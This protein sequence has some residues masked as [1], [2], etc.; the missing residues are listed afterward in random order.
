MELLHPANIYSEEVM[1]NRNR[2][3]KGETIGGRYL[4]Q[5]VLIGGMG[6]VYLCMDSLAGAPRA[7][8]TFQDQFLYDVDIRERFA[9]EALTWAKLGRHPNIVTVYEVEKI[10]GKP[11][12]IMEVVFGPEGYGSDLRSWLASGK[13]DFE[14]SMDFAVQFCQGMQFVQQ[15][16]PGLI[17]RDIKPENILINQNRILKISDFGLIKTWDDSHE[18]IQNT[19]FIDDRQTDQSSLVGTPGYMSPEQVSGKTLD[20]RSDIFSFGCVF[21]EMLTGKIPS[22]GSSLKQVDKLIEKIIT[23][24]LQVEPKER[25]DSFRG[26]E[27]AILQAYQELTGHS[28]TYRSEDTD[29][30]EIDLLNRAHSL[31]NLGYLDDALQE[32]DK[33]TKLYPQNAEGWSNKGAILAH[34]ER[35]EEALIAYDMAIKIDPRHY[36]A[37]LNKCGSL[38]KLNRASEAI[39]ILDFIL[40]FS[41]FPHRVW[42]NKGSAFEKLGKHDE[43]LDCYNRALQIDPLHTQSWNNKG[44]VEFSKYLHGKSPIDQ[45]NSL[46]NSIENFYKAFEIDPYYENA[47]NNLR[48]AINYALSDLP[49]SYLTEP[50]LWKAARSDDSSREEL[51]NKIFSVEGFE[52]HPRYVS[53]WSPQLSKLMRGEREALGVQVNLIC[54]TILQRGGSLVDWFQYSDEQSRLVLFMLNESLYKV[55]L[56]NIPVETAEHLPHYA[57]TSGEKLQIAKCM[58]N[59]GKSLRYLYAHDAALHCYDLG[60]SLYEDVG[61]LKF[62]GHL[63]YNKGLVYQDRNSDGDSDLAYESYMYSMALYKQLKLKQDVKAVQ[64]RLATL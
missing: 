58:N 24:C 51:F 55:G 64:E 10:D 53:E 27:E 4:V 36:N 47:R 56:F 8:K 9:K 52:F 22:M 25:Y 40:D 23:R 49:M 20:I 48:I 17:H 12:I 35:R 46:I 30:D 29:M 15:Q 14:T 21:Y 42:H 44:S 6:E 62:C 2:Y 18:Y 34:M 7:I 32:A 45:I 19:D 37:L 39:A 63:Y 60:I 28:M 43:A 33:F 16:N 5:K 26:L 31:F 41:P 38:I 3:Q 1:E 13:L 57:I 54:G 59:T 11:F 50:W 61:D